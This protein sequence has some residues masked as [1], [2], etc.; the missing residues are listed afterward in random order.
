MDSYYRWSGWTSSAV[1]LNNIYLVD[2]NKDNKSDIV[3]AFW[4]SVQNNNSATDAP[5]PNR[6]VILE[7]QPDG[8]YKDTTAAR[9]GTTNPVILG[10]E[11]GGVGVADFGDI[12]RDGTLD[13]LFALNRDDGRLGTQTSGDSYPTAI[14]SLPDGQYEIQKI[15]KPVWGYFPQLID[16]GNTTQ[17]W[18]SQSGYYA[19]SKTYGYGITGNV[20]GQPAYTYNTAN[21][22]WSVSGQPPVSG[23]FYVLPQQVS[24]G[25]VTQTLTMLWDSSTAFDPELALPGASFRIPIPALMQQTPSDD[26]VVQSTAKTFDYHPDQFTFNG[27]KQSGMVAYD[28]TDHFALIEYFYRP[29]HIE[30]FPGSNPVVMATRSMSLLDKNAATGQYTGTVNATKMDFF[31]VGASTVE[32]LPVKV[33]GEQLDLAAWSYRYLDFN[34]DG[35]TDIVVE[36]WHSNLGPQDPA[37]GAPAVYLNTGAGVFVHLAESLFPKA[38]EGWSRYAMSQVLDANGDGHFD[39]L[40]FPAIANGQF[41]SNLDWLLYLGNEATWNGAY[42]DPVQIMDRIHSPLIKTQAGNDL[43][44]DANAARLTHID[45]G[46]GVDT[47]QY[48]GLVGNYQ[49]KKSGNVWDVSTQAATPSHDT[50]SQV[51]RLQFADAFLAIDLDG[52]AGLVAKTLGAV[53]G[54]SAVANL[55]FVG[56]GLHFIDT[57][58]YSYSDL[59]QLAINARLGANP[60]S[61]Q[62]VDLL[63]T[64]VVGVAPDA[65]TRQSFTDLLDKH[66]Y[67]VASLGTLAADTELNQTNINLMGLQQVG[68]AYVPISG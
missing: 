27:N 4:Q 19:S 68:L 17:A 52:N 37:S 58:N 16:L 61:A 3:I 40:Y 62:V 14:M 13:M 38:P 65:N 24:Q 50:L 60:T 42:T 47:V 18:M 7:S 44:K 66:I 29:G 35:L 43:I 64:N 67:S 34:K 5:T 54:Q 49:I 48:A 6:L 31:S 36:G 26:W 56:I 28:G 32:K 2:L 8:S 20:D 12:N 11:L 30:L 33:V 39:L 25:R 1:N 10:G 55:D 63:Y 53:F 15:S 51:E 9:F 46:L 59:M 22:S 41:I 21:N 23:S 57:L 45:A